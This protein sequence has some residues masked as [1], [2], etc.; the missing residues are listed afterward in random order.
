MGR[1]QG[2]R[3]RLEVSAGDMA[4]VWGHSLASEGGDLGGQQ[5]EGAGRIAVGG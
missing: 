1:E 2:R 4:C 5:A 3:D